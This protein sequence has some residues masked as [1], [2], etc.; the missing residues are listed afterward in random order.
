MSKKIHI[1]ERQLNEIINPLINYDNM[2]GL[3]E[4]MTGEQRTLFEGLVKS[5][6]PEDVVRY[7]TNYFESGVVNASTKTYEG[8]EI[9]IITIPNDSVIE[10]KCIE[11]MDNLCG[12]KMARKG[13]SR[14]E[15][16]VR[17][18]FE[19]KFQKSIN[20]E[21]DEHEMLIHVSPSYNREKILKYGFC[22]KFKNTI[23]NYNDRIYFYSTRTQPDMV[24]RLAMNVA[25]SKDSDRND[26][27]FDFYMINPRK[28]DRNVEFHRDS[29][30]GDGVAYWTYDNIPSNCIID[31]DRVKF[32]MDAKKWE[33]VGN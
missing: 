7:I 17:L 18:H 12:Y 11:I 27:L 24:A 28:I 4:T 9:I 13:I 14:N 2:F 16:E 30:T 22:P 31:V 6:P 25:Y 15:S 10:K 1:N 8:V 29:M 33:Y 26:H 32:N 5:Y 21:M 3:V 19:P 23:F 20:D